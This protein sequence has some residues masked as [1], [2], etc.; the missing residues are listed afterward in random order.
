VG[1]LGLVVQQS[2]FSSARAKLIAS[3]GHM[4]YGRNP[5]ACRIDLI[6]DAAA[7]IS[8]GG[9]LIMGKLSWLPGGQPLLNLVASMQ[10]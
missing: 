1:Y 10:S 7:H 6:E 3:D 4:S 8:T 2:R 5:E 9:M